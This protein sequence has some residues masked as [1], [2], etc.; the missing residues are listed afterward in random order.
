MTRHLTPSEKSTLCCLYILQ[1]LPENQKSAASP[2]GT[3]NKSAQFSPTNFSN[4]QDPSPRLILSSAPWWTPLCSFLKC[5]HS[6]SQVCPLSTR[7]YRAELTWINL[8]DFPSFILQP[9][10]PAGNRL[11][12]KR[13]FPQARLNGCKIFHLF[14]NMSHCEHKEAFMQYYFLWSQ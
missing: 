9:S 1:D 14:S 3:Q 6:T 8:G 2:C 10:T 5:W 11:A 13:M 7:N 4:Y 12:L